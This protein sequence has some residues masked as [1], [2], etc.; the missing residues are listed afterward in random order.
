MSTKFATL[1]LLATAATSPAFAVE[2]PSPKGVGHIDH[3]FVLMMENHGYNQIVGNPYMPFIN[4]VEIP[5]ANVAL[6][7]FAV[8]HPSLTNYLEVIGGSN[9]GILDDNTTNYGSTSCASTLTVAGETNESTGG[10]NC[11]IAGSGVDAPTPVIDYSNETSG[12]PGD[13]EIDGVHSYAAASTTG[14]SIA[15][16]LTWLGLTWKTYQES[17]PLS[18]PWGITTSDGYFTD[19]GTYTPAE[20]ALGESGGNLA[21]LYRT[22]HNPF[23]YFGSV[24]STYNSTTGQVPGIASYE[25]ANGLWA[26]LATGH[27]PTYSFIAP[28]QCHDQHAGTSS[29]FSYPFCA[30]DPN[31]NGTQVGLNPGLMDV[32][33]QEIQAIVQAIKA[34]PV[35]THGRTA[36]VITWDENDYSVS[37]TTN[38]V[39]TIVD[40]NYGARGVMSNNYYTHFSLLKSIESG[41]GLPCLNHACDKSTAVM[42]DLFN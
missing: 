19:I 26:D 17:L 5:T 13:I 36:I 16:Q 29:G 35:W 33:D 25:G 37:P 21:K 9:F 3:V 4:N 42:K 11:P 6:N 28:N 7:Y 41:L 2:G 18:G 23:I 40:K 27:V 10:L 38:Q 34:S 20:T 24:Q 39:L 32:G 22:K 14:K 30:G 1:A 31:D 15:D 8:A 12:P